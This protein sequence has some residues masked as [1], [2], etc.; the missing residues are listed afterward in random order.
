MATLSAEFAASVAVHQKLSYHN[1]NAI[2]SQII[3]F[4]HKFCCYTV[5]YV[6]MSGIFTGFL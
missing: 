1:K 3:D 6:D 2:H 4:Y 5:K